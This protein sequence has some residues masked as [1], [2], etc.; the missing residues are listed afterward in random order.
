VSWIFLVLF[1]III[2]IKHNEHTGKTALS[3]YQFKYEEKSLVFNV[4]LRHEGREPSASWSE[5]GRTKWMRNRQG[6]T[7]ALLHKGLAEFL[8]F[9]GVMLFQV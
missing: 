6:A 8:I 9:G 3:L 1:I 5:G 4:K 2:S 7:S